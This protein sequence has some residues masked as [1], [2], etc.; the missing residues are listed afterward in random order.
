MATKD[1][2]PGLLSKVAQFVRNPTKD[3]S[4]IEQQD[5]QPDSGY[6]KQALK[7]MIE[8]K[9]QNDFVRKREFDQLR[10]LR[11]REPQRTSDQAG[12]PSFFQS[13]LPS[14]PDER[15]QTLKKI[16]EIEAQMSKQWWKGKQDG[17]TPAPNS[18]P[19]MSSPPSGSDDPTVPGPHT[20]ESA[21]LYQ[22]TEVAS[23]HSHEPGARQGEFAATELGHRIP[24]GFAGADAMVPYA[25]TAGRGPGPFF[26]A[27]AARTDGS[28]ATVYAV[29][30]AQMASDPDLEDAAIRFANSDDAGAEGGL[31]AALRGPNVPAASA[32]LWMAA[33]FDLYRAT[34]QQERF[35]AMAIEFAQSMGRSAPAWYSMPE[36]LVKTGAVS[37][38]VVVDPV[39][40]DPVWSSPE[41]LDADAVQQLVVAVTGAGALVHLDWSRLVRVQPEAIHALEQQFALWCGKKLKFCFTGA[42]S[43]DASLRSLTTSGDKDVNPAC[44]RLRLDGLRIMRLQDEFEMVALDYCVTYEVSPPPWREPLCQ[45]RPDQ[46]VAYP[47]KA[48]PDSGGQSAEELEVERSTTIP[49]MN[50]GAPA[51]LAVMEGEIAGDPSEVLTKLEHALQGGTRLLVSCSTLIRVDFAAAGSILNWVAGRQQEGCQVQFR[52]VHL[53]VAVF[54][55]VI[56]ITEHSKVTVQAH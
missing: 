53:L 51:P 47:A 27:E 45:Y 36:M 39:L 33:L 49:L 25:E 20:R 1:N 30:L 38:D 43:L 10:K 8:R 26:P 23:L 3:W 37:S 34:G 17:V 22:P 42:S 32:A 55:N 5:S 9:R 14:H 46:A 21:G 11:S 31:L 56:G 35:D 19:V 4:E 16:D 44:W 50:E 18:F 48:V 54:F 6:T 12:R 7:E 15:A 13:S 24:T 40:G 41:E 2:S 29:D 52:E 28:G